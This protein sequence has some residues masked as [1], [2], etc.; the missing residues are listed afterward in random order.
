MDYISIWKENE[1]KETLTQFKIF[2]KQYIE[3]IKEG[4]LPTEIKYNPILCARRQLKNQNI[5]DTDENI[6]IK[7]I[8]LKQICE[9]YFIKLNNFKEDNKYFLK[10]YENLHFIGTISDEQRIQ[11]A[12]EKSII[13]FKSDIDK[14]FDVFQTKVKNKI[15]NIIKI[16]AITDE[17]Y[18]FIGEIGKCKIK[19]ILA[20]GYNIQ[21]LH[22]RILIKNK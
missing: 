4:V 21:K 2:V 10:I 13:L 18:E 15:G 22:T 12:V 20:G 14:R 3:L 9:E 8:E 7:R 17:E 16:Q 1:L 6:N 19:V 5:P 11:E